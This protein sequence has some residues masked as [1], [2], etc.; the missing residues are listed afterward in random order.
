[1]KRD[2]SPSMER[3]KWSD[4]IEKTDSK[5]MSTEEVSGGE[6]MLWRTLYY[7][8]TAYKNQYLNPKKLKTF[9]EK[10]LKYIVDFAY[11]NSAFYKQK[12]KEAHITP[13]DIRTLDDIARIPLVTK[14]EIKE[15]FPAGILTPGF[16][17][18]NCEVRTTSGSSGSVFTVLIDPE[19]Q[20]YAAA[21]AFRDSLA[22]GVRP[23]HKF[24]ILYHDP[25]E[26]EKSSKKSLLYKVKGV[27]GV[28]PE[29]E[30]VDRAREYNPHFMGGH[31]SAFVAM[32][33][34]MEQK[35]IEDVN[36]HIIFLGGELV[37]PEYRKYIE[38]I[39]RCQIFS[40]YGAYETYSIAWECKHHRMHIDADSVL[41]EFIEEGEPVS[42]GERGE[43]VVTNLWNK[44]MP[45]I[46]YRIGDIGVPSDEACACGRTLPTMEGLEG[47]VDDF[48]IL[49]SGR[50]VPPTRLIPPFFMTPHIEEFKMIQDIK[51]HIKI[52]IVPR[53]RL[54]EDEERDLLQKVR[55]IL[56]EPVDI[57]VEFTDVIEKTGIGKFKAVM[58]KMKMDLAS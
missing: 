53:G 50:A 30:L 58:S 37:Y 48:I 9:Q 47:R 22:L 38:R 8:P 49:P 40:K 52:L 29:E 19:A 2:G 3:M 25:V 16:S 39:F 32:A 14:E 36:P 51:T 46:R 12:F 35:G 26:L 13:H 54:P 34:V 5:E 18:H 4:E 24:Y 31:P 56:A 55:D 45:F 15:V 43:I 41:V 21:V 1:M 6:K 28:L 44:A 17:E 57:D 20:D 7:F 23:W 33:K 27:P 11:R 10:R 42:P